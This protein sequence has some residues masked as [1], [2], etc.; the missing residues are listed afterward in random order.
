MNGRLGIV[1]GNDLVRAAVACQ[2]GRRLLFAF[3]RRGGVNSLLEAVDGIFVAGGALLRNDFIGVLDFVRLAVA[4]GAGILAE[5]G[6][7][8]LRN[9]RGFLIVAGGAGRHLHLRGM[10][11]LFHAFVTGG[12]AQIAVDAVFVLGGI[13][14]QA[15]AGAGL[16]GGIAVAGQAFLIGGEGG[17]GGDRCDDES[18]GK[19]DPDKSPSCFA[20]FTDEFLLLG[21]PS[22][23]KAPTERRDLR[24]AES[25]RHSHE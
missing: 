12:A 22:G 14:V 8:A 15:L 11:K 6:V 9:L 10:G 18:E 3:L 24:G 5:N 13:D 25:A 17:R 1:G 20:A 4:T 7:D 16:H 19:A 21:W 2:A 23:A